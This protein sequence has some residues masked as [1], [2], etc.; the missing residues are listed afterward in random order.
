MRRPL[1]VLVL[2]CSLTGAAPAAPKKQG[3]P[4]VQPGTSLKPGTPIAMVDGKPVLY[5]E[6]EGSVGG[7][8][9]QAEAEYLNKAYTVTRGA[10]DQLV[11]K[12][13]L[14]AEAG[15]AG[16]SVEE[17]MKQ[18][19]LPSVP[20]PTDDEVKKVFEESKRPAAELEQAAPGLREQLR[21]AA[22]QQRFGSLL[23]E[24]MTKHQVQTLLTAP[25][26]VRLPV[27]ASGPAKGSEKAKVT[28]VEFSD[29][30]CPYC[31]RVNPTI[32]RVMQ[33]YG[34]KVRVVYRQFPLPFHAQAQKAAEASLCA[35]DQGK[36]W[37]LHD[38]MFAD[39]GKLAVPD[40]KAAAR[41]LGL[42]GARFDACLDGG[43]KG[44]LVGADI[45]AAKAVGVQGTPAFFINGVFLNGAVP[46]EQ[47]Q[48]VIERELERG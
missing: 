20:E 13:L 35:N 37:S 22:G 11:M 48:S 8:V 44:S 29:F 40:L 30:Q 10:L 7:V 14:E 9:R 24:L 4:Q 6:I 5:S 12:R 21:R 36:F 43:G 15:K 28:I 38:R 27:A 23:Q 41:E 25:E 17:W 18:D 31:S 42:D 2:T 1:L 39:Q 32:E 26:P 16:K 46:F 33:G 19:F 47:F 3:P 34:D 45:D